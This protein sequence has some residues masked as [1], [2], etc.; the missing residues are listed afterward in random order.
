MVSITGNWSGQRLV[1]AGC[2]A[3]SWGI[4]HSEGV[5]LAAKRKQCHHVIVS[6]LTNETYLHGKVH[7]GSALKTRASALLF[8]EGSCRG[9]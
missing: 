8:V 5:P 2:N 4:N 6:S 9:A 1:A 3:P 7:S